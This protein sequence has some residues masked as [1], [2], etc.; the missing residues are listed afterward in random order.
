MTIVIAITSKLAAREFESQLDGCVSMGGIQLTYVNQSLL[1]IST[2]PHQHKIPLSPSSYQSSRSACL[3]T[4]CLHLLHL[5]S[6]CPS[7]V[8]DFQSCRSRC[9]QM[10]QTMSSGCALSI[11]RI[12][13]QLTGEDPPS[14]AQSA[15]RQTVLR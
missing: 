1:C 14:S 11:P 3:A 6:L 5:S 4:A 9:S 10:S 15:Q 12:I 13:H 2:F 7:E 8:I